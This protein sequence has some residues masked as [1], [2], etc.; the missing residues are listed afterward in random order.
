MRNR[1]CAFQPSLLPNLTSRPAT[2]GCARSCGS[3]GD[4]FWCSFLPAYRTPRI[5]DAIGCSGSNAK[6]ASTGR[7]ELVNKLFPGNDAKGC[8]CKKKRK[9]LLERYHVL[10]R[11]VLRSTYY[12]QVTMIHVTGDTATSW[13]IMTH[14]I[15]FLFSTNASRGSF[16]C[17]FACAA[18]VVVSPCMILSASSLEALTE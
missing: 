5:S 14:S 16:R 3:L 1:L 17:C 18:V 4:D 9:T 7:L 8:Q 13:D 15:F 11:T 12:F 2:L 6:S 10:L